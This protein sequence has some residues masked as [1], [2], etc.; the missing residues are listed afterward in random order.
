MA[1]QIALLHS[2]STNVQYGIISYLPVRAPFEN[3]LL[4]I[5]TELELTPNVPDW[6][7][8]DQ[9]YQDQEESMI[10]FKGELKENPKRSFIISSVISRALDPVAICV[11]VEE[12]STKRCTQL[13]LRMV[14]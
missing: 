12:R 4:T 6:D 14:Q 13:K 10:T 11:D 7:P 1:S 2:V 8:H 9:M 3:E 5:S